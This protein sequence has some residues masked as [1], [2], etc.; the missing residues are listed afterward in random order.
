ML[1]LLHAERQRVHAAREPPDHA[2]GVGAPHPGPHVAGVQAADHTQQAVDRSAEEEVDQHAGHDGAPE[3]Q[4]AQPGKLEHEQSVGSAVDGLTGQCDHHRRVPG[5]A[6]VAEQRLHQEQHGQPVDPDAL[7]HAGRA[8]GEQPTERLVDHL[9]GPPLGPGDAAEDDA[10]GVDSSI[11]APAGSGVSSTVRA[12][13]PR[14]SATTMTARTT[15]EPST[16][17]AESVAWGG[18]GRGRSRTG[19]AWGC[20]TRS[21]GRCRAGR[22]QRAG[23][24]RGVRHRR[25]GHRASPPPGRDSPGTPSPRRR[26]GRCRARGWP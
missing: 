11:E 4:H 1:V 22:C 21:C 6:R 13:W 14:S 20:R 15:P 25:P 9:A 5:S 26:R 23:S 17:G 24:R 12:S 19:Q 7:L 18:P 16:A 3:R 8:L 2:G 10:V